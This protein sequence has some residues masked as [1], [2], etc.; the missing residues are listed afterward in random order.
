MK[1]LFDTPHS[2]PR[3]PCPL[4]A[5]QDYF[6]VRS[7][8]GTGFDIFKNVGRSSKWVAHTGK[9]RSPL[10]PAVDKVRRLQI[11]IDAQRPLN[12]TLD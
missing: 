7:A 1:R 2:S 8:Q 6:V 9:S 10:T 4:Y 11:R 3:M 12:K 5:T